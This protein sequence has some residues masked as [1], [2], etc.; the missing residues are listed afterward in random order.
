M[1]RFKGSDWNCL[2]S[3]FILTRQSW[4]LLDYWK[5]DHVDDVTMVC[6][7][8]SPF[9]GKGVWWWAKQ[10]LLIKQKVRTLQRSFPWSQTHRIIIWDCGQI[11]TGAIQGLARLSH[12][13]TKSVHNNSTEVFSQTFHLTTA[14]R[15][16]HAVEILELN[17]TN[18]VGRFSPHLASFQ[19][20]LGPD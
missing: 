17:N 9:L 5:V 3:R 20:K 19:A 18:L 1:F 12:S 13:K 6:K 2:L 10:L 11:L 7:V 15:R 4:W 16:E 8:K 14:A